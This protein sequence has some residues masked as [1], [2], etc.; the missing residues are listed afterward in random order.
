MHVD[1][2]YVDCCCGTV[3]EGPTAIMLRCPVTSSTGSWWL[4]KL[5]RL[6]GASLFAVMAAEQL[7]KEVELN[8]KPFMLL[9]V[10]DVHLEICN[11]HN[12]TCYDRSSINECLHKNGICKGF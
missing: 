12:V 4:T 6:A 2:V 1:C 10:N 8:F 11:K 9:L 7:N 5:R 3:M